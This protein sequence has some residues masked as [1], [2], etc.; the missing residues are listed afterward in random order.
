[1]NSAM[2]SLKN[3]SY[4]SG[5]IVHTVNIGIKKEVTTK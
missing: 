4:T 1:M 3:F 5:I 2:F